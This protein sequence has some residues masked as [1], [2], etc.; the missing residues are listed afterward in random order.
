MAIAS[1]LALGAALSWCLAGVFGHL[2]AK[3]LGSVHFNRLRML[4]SFLM[5]LV[6]VL[7]TGTGVG[8]ARADM[9]MIVLSGL[10]GAAGGDFFL[11]LTMRRLAPR[12]TGVLFAANAPMAAF[13]GWLLLDEA[14]TPRI[15][16]AIAL[17][18]AGIVLAVIYGKRRDLIHVWEDLTPP[19]WLGVVFGLMAALG[20]AIGVLMMRPVMESGLDPATAG[21]WRV[22]VA[23]LVFWLFLPIERWQGKGPARILP[24]RDLVPHI[25]GNGFFGMAFGMALLL[26]ALETGPVGMVSILSSTAPL[27]MLPFVWAKTRLVP[28][29]GAWIGAGLVVLCSALLI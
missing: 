20:Q 26:K 10:I 17:G 27:M 5:L 2:P 22:T 23:M 7:V 29:I 4:T 25:I 24:D 18:F 13:L 28:P 16:L 11:F 3:R 8:V 1:L 15:L 14:L 6:Y 19:L 21:L 12:R 9:M